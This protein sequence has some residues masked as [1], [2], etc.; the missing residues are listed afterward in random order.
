MK[1][2]L[3]TGGAGFIGSHLARRLVERGD[4][5]TI[6]DN[7]STGSRDNLPPGT[8]LLYLDLSSPAFVAALPRKPFDAVC[9]LAAQSSGEVSHE[10]PLYDI[11]VNTISTL[12]LTRWCRAQGVGRLLYGSSMAV[13]G[14]PE[15]L[16]IREEH[17]CH[18]LSYYGVSKVTSE[19]YLWLAQQ[20]GLSTTALRMFSVYGPGQNL[21]NLKQGM[22]S[23]YLAYLLRGEPIVVKGSMERF[24][25]FIYI[26]DVVDGWLTALER[27]EADEGVFNLASGAP[28]T[29]QQL[30]DQL[31][32][33]FG[34]DPSSYPVHQESPTPGDQ[35]GIYADI[36]RIS[37]DLAWIPRIGLAEGLEHMIKW[38]MAR[39]A[40]R[41]A[42]TGRREG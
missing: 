25:D 1:R 6:V 34:E 30:L 29:V 8:S 18:P 12:L 33:A 36:S 2:I 42:M 13:Y 28:T 27:P 7:L 37:T 15:H 40:G 32:Q 14:E 31:I 3:V 4:Q 16:P 20:D 41:A 9:H 19:H 11:R 24:R 5:V 38:A 23:I 22:V 39:Q 17:P 26:D 21:G 10:D 35:F